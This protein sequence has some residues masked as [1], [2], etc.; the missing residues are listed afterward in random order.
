MKTLIYSIVALIVLFGVIL[1][2]LSIASRKQPELGLVDGRL[3]PCPA[4]PNCV[5]SEYPGEASYIEPL[6]YTGSAQDAWSR[7][8]Q[9]IAGTGGEVIARQDNYLRA[10][11]QT[12]LLRF[13]D[14]V[15]F[16]LDQRQEVIQV[17][18]ASRVGRSDLGANRQRV[19]RIREQ[20]GKNQ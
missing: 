9:V 17:R 19:A 7:L 10:V 16:R 12:P 20:F 6:A 13:V 3:Q 8:E 14:D 11:Y 4:S 15:E 2:A 1:V 18:S 5:C